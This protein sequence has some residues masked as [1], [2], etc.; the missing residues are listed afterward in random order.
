MS[1]RKKILR[2]AGWIFTILNQAVMGYLTIFLFS[3]M[4]S[5]LLTPDNT[6]WGGWLINLLL[7]WLGFGI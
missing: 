3:V 1:F 4:G 7:V 2:I 5:T 6:S